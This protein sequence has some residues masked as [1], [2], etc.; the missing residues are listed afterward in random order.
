MMPQQDSVQPPRMAVWLV[1]LF[2]SEDQD[3]PILGDL[4][5]EFRAVAL[6]SGVAPA[7]SWYWRQVGKTL[8]QLIAG[9]FRIAPWSI[10]APV[11]ASVLLWWLAELG[12]WAVLSKSWR[13]PQF[14]EWPEVLRLG[15]FLLHR[16]GAVIWLIYVLIPNATLA[17][18]IGWAVAGANRGREVVVALALGLVMSVLTVPAVT[19]AFHVVGMPS[20]FSGPRAL[21]LSITVPIAIVIGGIFRRKTT[22]RTP[23]LSAS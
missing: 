17:M 12:M 16:N 21:Q 14:V 20:S 13:F 11:L 4:L 23:Q 2:A 9:Q 7:R 22:R 5:E 6:H 8:V 10:T 18:L 3:A 19:Y 1:D 15:W